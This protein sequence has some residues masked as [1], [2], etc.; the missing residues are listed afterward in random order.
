MIGLI[1]FFTT[2]LEYSHFTKLILRYNNLNEFRLPRSF[3]DKEQ[4]TMMKS[5]INKNPGI[6]EHSYKQQHLSHI[7]N[8]ETLYD[9]ITIDECIKPKNQMF[10]GRSEIYWRYHPFAVD[11]F[12]RSIR[13]IGEMY[14]LLTGFKRNWHKTDDGYYSVYTY[15]V[16]N[17]NKRP[18]IFFPGF[19]LGAIPYAHIAKRMNR[20]VYIIE[21]P[22]MGYATPLSP[23]HGTAKTIYEV[24]T[25]YTKDFDIISHS[26]G[27]GHCGHLI[28]KLFL[29]NELSFVKNVI[30][31]DGFVNP[32]DTIKSHKYP[33]VDY[34]DYNTVHKKTRTKREFLMFIYFAAHNLEFNSWAKRY[35][36]LYDGV[37]WRDYKG[38]NIHYIYGD[39]DIL[40]DTDYISK[41]SD[42]HV[43]K[44]ASHG[45]C[46]FGKRSEHTIQYIK[47]SLS[48]GGNRPNI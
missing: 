42:C 22:N 19:G 30:I 48:C 21:V 17:G 14:M 27:S 12:M 40:Y 47:H 24:V 5:I 25:K 11:L 46:L 26:M 29:Q 3:T 32:V 45:A 33:F 9:A 39:K 15:R 38:V 41:Y 43:I 37:L 13:K 7:T 10:V 36:N 2:A 20:T 34:C 35:H 6:F 16:I 18:I 23:R 31:C 8:E 1:L 4:L 44:N 28:N